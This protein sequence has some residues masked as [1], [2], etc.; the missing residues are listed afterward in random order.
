[1]PSQISTPTS[2][3]K[4]ISPSY[5]N[6]VPGQPDFQII[7]L[8]TVGDEVPL[9]TN[10]YSSSLIPTVDTTRKYAFAGIPDGL[11]WQEVSVG[12][13]TYKY[14]WVNHEIGQTTSTEISST[15]A[16]K[17]ILGARVSLFVFDGSWNVIGG[18]NLIE[19]AIDTT[20]TYTLN[21]T[22]GLYT[23]ATGS[24]LVASGTGAFGRFCSAFLA[25]TGF[26][27]STGAQVPVFFA[28]EES[29]SL[30][31]SWAVTPD[32]KALA[33]DSLGRYSKENV[34]AASQ[35]RPAI[36]PTTVL[37]AAE[38]TSDGELY[39]W[40]GKKTAQDPNGFTNGDLYVL[41]VGTNDHTGTMVEGT[42]YTATWTKVD[43]SAVFNAD[44]TPKPNGD[45]LTAFVNASSRSTN[46]Q[47]IE[48]LAEDPNAPG[49]FYFV[50]TGTT[51]KPGTT[52][53][54]TGNANIAATPAEAEDPY[55]KLYRFSLNPA[56][57]TGQINNFQV[58][59]TGGPNKGAS[60]DNIV[61]DRN[62][63]VALM[64]DETAFGGALYASENREAGIWFF[65]PTTKEVS[66]QF[67]LNES[68]GGSQFNNTEKKGE[69]E[70][71]GIVEVPYTG[72]KGTTGYLFDV[73]AHTIPGTA[74]GLAVDATNN[75]NRYAEGGQLILALPVQP[76][77]TTGFET[78][79]P[80]QVK[81][82]NGYR[83]D[84]IFTIGET[85]NSYT[86]PGI[87]DGTGAYQLNDTTV[88]ILVNHELGAN[89]GYAY[90]LKSGA[91]ITGARIS[92]FDIDKRTL[93]VVDSGL[94]YNTIYNRG[95]AVVKAPEDLEYKGIDRF[96]AANLMEANLFGPGKG[97]AD[98]IYFAGE[99][100]NGGTQF[101][102]NTAAGELWALPWM[103]RAAWES[104][105]ELD[106]GT[107]DKIALLI[108]D[109]RQTAPLLL[110]V[111]EKNVKK[112]NSFLDRNGLGKGKLYVW[113][114]DDPTSATD[115]IEADP[116]DFKGSGQSLA[117]KFV[118]IDYYRLDKAGTDGYDAQGFASQTK[119]D[120]LAADAKAFK[121]SRPED[122]ATNPSNGKQAVLAS[123]G[124]TGVFDNADTWGT[125]YKIDVNFGTEITANLN[126]L[127]D[128]NDADKKDF[129]LRS[130][131][132][133]DWADDGK[134]YL[135]E[136]RAISS[137]LFGATSKQ[138]AS[139]WRIDPAAA[140]PAATA[141]RIAQIDRSGL[142]SNQT[143]ASPTDIGNWES[144]GILDVSYLFGNDPGEI[145]F[146]DVQAHS[147]TN[148][149]I[150]RVPGVDTDKDGIVE[151]SDNL[152]EGGQLLFLISPNASL[153]QDSQLVSASAGT[154]IVVAKVTANFDGTNDIVFTGAGDDRVEVPIAGNLAGNNS[155]FT[156]SGKDTIFVANG[157]RTFGGSGDDIISATDAKD[158]RI[159]GG[160]GNDVFDLGTN[161]RA[162][163]GDGDDKFFVTEG[164]GNLISGGTG[165]DQFWITTG[166]IPSADNQLK[167]NTIVDFQVGTDVLGIS[168]QGQNFGFGNLTLTNDNII[169]NG[170]II[171]T[172]IGVNT[173]TL[174]ASNFS[175]K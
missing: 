104:V 70:S 24:T 128:G 168:G 165:A 81:G 37:F 148:G 115:P 10:T 13:K 49:T 55:G 130:P 72:V 158:Y 170:N 110:Y 6:N 102:L 63:N 137:T 120:A 58:V 23:S 105:T 117:G 167:P 163:G 174:T 14:V 44:N 152:V 42:S 83:I 94:A 96:C 103:G 108:G 151:A 95:G 144:S 91:F 61:V 54:G 29:G 161:G 82:L 142:P 39:M 125:T 21:T 169:I 18:K 51:Q 139:I 147:L 4:T 59:L 64:E 124:R 33:L 89:T 68:A 93:K 78:K 140:N 20:G 160:S 40:V 156:G 28:P 121:F 173:S 166:D 11:G 149:N 57:P 73:Q 52:S 12:G 88:R 5:V 32:G 43:K 127:Y 154:D 133:L 87:P 65:N 34:V 145:L 84:P 123:T 35:Y 100:T 25:N 97:F 19:T 106:T 1:M 31:R 112:D 90:T 22:T 26:F 141:T 67:S 77:N 107:T 171:A 116:R 36:S 85:I 38:D 111:G 66:Q 113:V 99:E 109:D 17:K 69:W 143:D 159:S 155:V 71:S 76:I 129:G 60:Y 132:N 164:G 3:G 131:D 15:E 136:D 122:V 56:D 92:Y 8:I 41:R 146:F 53:A 134:I 62:G 50:T 86:P 47:R 153:I 2:P 101:A 162:L 172:L 75:P 74:N 46:F 135:Q 48:D 175:F 27:D 114:A 79:D 9:L 7:P 157:D 45:E 118:E 80:A 30:A 119:Q 98:R 138:E 16:G 150:I 126:I